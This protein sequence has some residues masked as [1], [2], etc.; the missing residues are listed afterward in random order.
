MLALLPGLVLAACSAPT[1][2][3]P[4]VRSTEVLGPFTGHGAPL[5]GDN[6]RPERIAYYGTDLGFS[7]THH[8]QIHFLFGDTWATE[9]Y[10]P[11]EASTGGR[12]DDGFGTIELDDWPDAAIISADDL[13]RIKL[14][15]APDGVEM[16]AINPGQAMDLGKTPMAAFSNGEREF[17]IFN[18]TKPQGC[19]TDDD[20][21]NG[22]RCD[23]GLGFLGTRYSEEENLTIACLDGDT[24]CQADTMVD[25]EGADGAGS[26]FC[27][28]RGS[29]AWADTPAGRAAAVGIRQRVGV[30]NTTDPRRYAIVRDWLTNKFLNVTATTVERFVPGAAERD[31]RPA[32]GVGPV[33][34]V[35][36]W[37]RPGFVGVSATDRSMGLYFAYVDLPGEP[38]FDWDIHYY[39][40]SAD[41]IPQFSP[42]EQ[43]AA[44]LDLDSSTEGLQPTE[45]HD[46]VH[47]MTVEWI[48]QLHKWL[49]FYGGG[50]STLPSAVLPDCGV[51]QLFAQSECGQV[52][53]GNGA[54]RMRAAV[55]PWG[56]WSPPRDVIV[57]GNP[58][59]TG[60]GQ[61]GPG[62]M[63]HHPACRG[64]SCAPHSNTPFYHENEYGFFYSANIIVPW[65]TPVGDSVD[66]LWNAS[67]WDPY[68]VVLLRTRIDP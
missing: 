59:V 1:E 29:S 63:L 5:H 18:L 35:F 43:D 26:G 50:V 41:G 54:I 9:A 36:L 60:S 17:A 14:G 2:P 37:G 34:R 21:R 13:P 58:D 3:G 19:H 42:N 16:S 61:Y 52:V 40:G 10:A 32:S 4:T 27:A 7:Y 28:D 45:V 30:R 56:P 57:G 31:Y 22:L 20:C 46:V 24:Y 47:Q 6:E 65:I 62:G 66:I 12:F 53:V 39:T 55:N 67:T 68:R 8:G 15:Q 11:I 38:D 33:Q 23:T 49:M 44:A 51:L 25:E 64:G 48:P